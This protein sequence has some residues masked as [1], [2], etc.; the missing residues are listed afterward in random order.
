MQCLRIGFELINV[1]ARAAIVVAP[2]ER[3]VR[4]SGTQ[5]RGAAQ[6][7]VQLHES[8]AEVSRPIATELRSRSDRRWLGKR[9]GRV[10]RA[11]LG[12]VGGGGCEGARGLGGGT[13]GLGRLL[14]GLS[15]H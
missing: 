12:G 1:S 15:G 6:K 14:H 7:L 5:R 3:R 13:D 4:R 11:W 10:H 9:R 2:P 8:V